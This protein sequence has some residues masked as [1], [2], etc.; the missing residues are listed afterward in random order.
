MDR[1]VKNQW[2]D[3]IMSLVTM[4]AAVHNVLMLSNEAADTFFNILDNV[5]AIPQLIIDPNADTID[6]RTVFNTTVES[7]FKT[8]FGVEQWAEIKTRWG[9]ANRIYQAAANSLN[10]VRN[11]GGNIITAIEQTGELTGKGFNALQNDGLLSELNWNTAPEELNL[12]GGLYAK[13]DKLANGISVV[14][15]GL[16]AIESITGEVR[17]AVDSANQIKTNATEIKTALSDLTAQ[18]T[19]ERDA[20]IEQLPALDFDY[21]DLI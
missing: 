10:E 9:A 6:S 17:S 7:F 5:I 16:Q 1:I 14:T 11:I 8:M 12:K 3:R 4:S 13:L 2:V 19:G 15:T 20:E 21:L 18:K